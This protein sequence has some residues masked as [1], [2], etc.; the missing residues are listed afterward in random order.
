MRCSVSDCKGFTLVE[1]MIVVA[2]LGIL[3]AVAVP[4][5]MNHVMRVR[6]A[7]GIDKLL[8]IKASQEKY[9]ALYDTYYGAGALATAAGTFTDLLSFDPADT[10]YYR[11]TIV[12]GGSTAF[13]ALAE[14]DLNKDGTR[15]DCWDISNSAS[16]PSQNT[17]DAAC[18]SGGEDFQL[19]TITSIL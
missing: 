5:Y 12:S 14:G 9:Y 15:T 16:D 8:D 2:I 13:T 6:Q 7:Q 17:T 4:A 10:T 18:A 19:S 1:L 11:F 3:S